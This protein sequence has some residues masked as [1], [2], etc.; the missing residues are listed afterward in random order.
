MDLRGATDREERIV[1][2]VLTS[3]L[4]EAAP[5]APAVMAGG[6]GAAP[7]WRVRLEIASDPDASLE[8]ELADEVVLGRD[9]K[10][11]YV[12]L[13]AHNAKALGV[14]R[15]HA[16]LCPS[17]TGLQV[18]DLDST[19]GTT[20]NS[21]VLRENT[22]YRVS[23]GDVLS[24]GKLAITVKIL[25]GS[26][27]QIDHLR[28]QAD[29]A[30]ALTQMAKAIT[31]QIDL[32]DILSQALEMA[33]SL[34]AAREAAVW[35]VD[36]RTHELFLEAERGIED[37]QIRRMRLPVADTMVGK[38]IAT[39]KPLSA[40][41]GA[42]GEE[43]KVKTGYTVEALLYVPLI[44]GDE[45]VGVLAAAHRE[46]GMVFS[47]RDERLLSAIGDF[48]A[49]ALHN[50][51][52]YQRLQEG[53]QLK[54]QMIQ[55]ISHEFRTPLQHI[56]GYVELAL[57]PLPGEERLPDVHRERLEVV[58]SQ[59]NKLTWLVDNF[60]ALRSMGEIAAER[61]RADLAELLKEAEEG[62][63]RQA[64]ER[65]INITIQV[66]GTLP[67]VMVNRPAMSLVLDNLLANAIKFTP[68]GGRVVVQAKTS[69]TGRE[70]HV[71]VADTGIGIPED[72]HEL[73]F[74][75]FYQLDGTKTRR[76]GG[77]GLGLSVCKAIV[78]AHDGTI[79]IDKSV[80]GKGTLITFS[81]PA[82][83]QGSEAGESSEPT[84]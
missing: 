13:S 2:D 63:K 66:Q 70:V 19:N 1:L 33:M 5:A 73:I 43:I 31:S 48:A 46:P 78:E 28:H 23:D 34:T 42:S 55:N 68:S 12:D 65:Q 53:N 83:N 67:P 60:I 30:D 35:L 6:E 36:K 80:L 25:Q 64:S 38:V 51:R 22:P 9:H 21:D 72:A 15:H 40:A 29:L 77:V 3:Q 75:R 27:L 47:P 37:E 32:D 58:A 18:I 61:A 59:A 54:A 17:E 76:F 56:V 79:W 14:S 82:V 39:G 4:D 20:L 84:T 69:P 26:D 41:R 62:A 52:L 57:D 24:L 7:R 74:E 8:L 50:S 45:T 81:I 16:K 49:I 10:R 44:H 11:G 71:S